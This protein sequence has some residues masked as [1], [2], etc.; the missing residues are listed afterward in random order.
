M[1]IK[2]LKLG[3]YYLTYFPNVFGSI[4]TELNFFFLQ[5]EIAF[6]FCYDE[7]CVLHIRDESL[8]ST[9]LTNITLYVNEWEF[10]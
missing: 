2:V 9:P 10:K 4:T 7:H 3:L 5:I 8:N 1:K 6:L